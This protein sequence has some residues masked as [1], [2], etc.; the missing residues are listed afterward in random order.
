MAV[1][2]APQ[3]SFLVDNEL[4]LELRS[5]VRRS[6]YAVP[7]PLY[8]GEGL[9][10]R[11]RRPQRALP[12]TTGAHTGHLRCY[13]RAHSLTSVLGQESHP[14]RIRRSKPRAPVIAED[15]FAKGR[16]RA[17]HK[18]VRGA[19]QCKRRT[20]LAGSSARSGPLK[21]MATAARLRLSSKIDG[22]FHGRGGLSE[23]N[24]KTDPS[25][26]PQPRQKFIVSAAARAAVMV[27][28]VQDFAASLTYLT[29]RNSR[30]ED[31]NCETCP[32]GPTGV[33]GRLLC[34]QNTL[35]DTHL[36]VCAKIWVLRH[37][38]SLNGSKG[39]CTGWPRQGENSSFEAF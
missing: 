39:P 37:N 20:Q 17:R 28:K 32:Q 14:R 23:D 2:T 4:A 21:M 24:S 26:E 5:R 30:L 16:A 11:D 36:F 13:I 34:P 7:R 35:F 8:S 10:L 38:R 22:R 12:V 27:V 29:L 15:C 18:T 33:Q 3:P 6:H 9:P 19:L 1:V 25:T 31:T